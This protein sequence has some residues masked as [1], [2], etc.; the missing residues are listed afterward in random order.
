MYATALG[1]AHPEKS[2]LIP[3]ETLEFLGFILDSN[4]FTITLTEKRI[5]KILDMCKTF[6][7]H[8]CQTIKDA[9]SLVGCLIAALPAV[10]YGALFYRRLERCENISLRRHKGNFK[11]KAILTEDALSDVSWWFTTVR[12]SSNFIHPP[13]V[14]ATLYA[15]V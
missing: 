10:K 3:T 4:R 7:G 14:K 15:D 9:A 13:P 12:A 11:K 2:V 5:Q 6:L 8:P 1:M